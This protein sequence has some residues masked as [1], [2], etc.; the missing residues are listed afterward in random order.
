MSSERLEI[1]LPAEQ[2]RA[3]ERRAKADRTSVAEVC[4]RS[5]DSY[6]DWAFLR[7]V[8]LADVH[9]GDPSGCWIVK[10]MA[11]ECKP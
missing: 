9:S 11:G 1:T 2:K 3:L 10:P 7:A 8:S 6:F 5:I 4:R